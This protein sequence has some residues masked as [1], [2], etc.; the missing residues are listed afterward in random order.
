MTRDKKCLAFCEGID[1]EALD[2]A[3]NAEF[4]A[5]MLWKQRDEAFRHLASIGHD[6]YMKLEQKRGKA[7]S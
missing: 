2:I 3:I 7:D 6:P 5:L 1:D 4:G